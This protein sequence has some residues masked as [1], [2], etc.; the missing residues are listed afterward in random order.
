MPAKPAELYFRPHMSPSADLLALLEYRMRAI[1]I[2]HLA[3]RYTMTW[4][5]TPRMKVYFDDL[6]VM[7]GK[8]TGFTNAAIESAIVH[9]RALLEFVGLASGGTSTALSAI[10]SKRKNDDHAIER[11]QGLNRVSVTD[12]I[13]CYPGP[14]QEAE[15]A[16]AY[17]I[18]LANKGLAHTSTV[19]ARRTHI[20]R[21]QSIR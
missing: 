19:S 16:L 2:G 8:A 9:C 6:Q 12:A 10:K 15:S 18:Y 3:L 14:A 17:V 11:F 13:A 1:A 7:E 20:D 4:E 5:D 21:V